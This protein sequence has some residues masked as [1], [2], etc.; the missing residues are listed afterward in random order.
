MT[1]KKFYSIAFALLLSATSLFAQKNTDV[2]FVT[3]VSDGDDN[4]T[5]TG[6]VEDGAVINATTITDDGFQGAFI[7]AG[8]G[9]ENTTDNGKRVQ[10]AYKVTTLDNGYVQSCF[11][12]SCTN[13]EAVGQY[14]VPILS[15]SNNHVNLPVLRKSEIKDIA[16]E[17]KFLKDGKATV[18]LTILIGTKNESKTDAEGEVYDVVEGPSV[19]VNF[20]KG[21]AAGINSTIAASAA[22]TVYYDLTGRKV[23]SP[24]HGVYVQKQTL[25]DG[26]VK[27]S[28]VM[29]K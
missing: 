4:I 19:T 17:W 16:T 27:T 20:L 11:Q 6:E 29:V 10:I 21:A 12:S 7:S 13:G 23:A 2:R 1:M 5:K 22:K 14:Y 28:K 18:T 26:T 15:K 25:S 3:I 8:L 9:V 24:D